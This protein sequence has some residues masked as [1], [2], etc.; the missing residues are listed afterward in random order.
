MWERYFSEIVSFD[1]HFIAKMA[2]FSILKKIQ[3]FF[4]KTDH[5]FQNP[6]FCKFWEF[7]YYG[8]ILRQ[9]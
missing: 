4:Q 2:F 7:Y 1:A 6:K 8:R 3:D 9:I 5:F